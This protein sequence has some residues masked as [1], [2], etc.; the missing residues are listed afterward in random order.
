MLTMLVQAAVRRA[1]RIGARA[2]DARE[3]S[4]AEAKF[5]AGLWLS[6]FTT[7]YSVFGLCS[8]IGYV[9]RYTGEIFGSMITLIEIVGAHAHRARAADVCREE[10]ESERLAHAEEHGHAKNMKRMHETTVEKFSFLKA[11]VQSVRWLRTTRRQ[12][13][14]KPLLGRRVV[15]HVDEVLRLGGGLLLQ[16]ILVGNV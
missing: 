7:L 13:Q 11:S 9:T 2:Q 3:R 16:V 12:S 15:N 6:I 8:L 5:W 14:Y 1:D 10:F 4:R